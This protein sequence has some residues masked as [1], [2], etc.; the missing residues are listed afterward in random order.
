MNTEQNF[1][2]STEA[3]N[4]TKPALAEGQSVCPCCGADWD[5]GDMRTVDCW[6]CG[7]SGRLKI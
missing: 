7:G 2:N 1:Q 5:D 6:T 4:N 3:S